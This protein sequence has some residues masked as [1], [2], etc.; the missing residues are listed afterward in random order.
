MDKVTQ[1]AIMRGT[2]IVLLVT[3][4]AILLVQISNALL[5]FFAAVIIA[6]LFNAAGGLFR[7]VGLPGHLATAL[8][9]LLVL[10]ILSLLIWLFAVE[11]AGQWAE[12][13]QRFSQ[14]VSM[15]QQM[16][17]NL[18]YSDAILSSTDGIPNLFRRVM[19]FAFG[20]IGVLT[21]L[22]LVLIGAVYLAAQPELYARGF[23]LL[24]P[25]QYGDKVEAALMATG[26]AL[27]SYLLGQFVTMT[28]IGLLVWIGLSLIGMPSAAALGLIIALANF[29]PMVG[30]FI[31]AAP[32][33]LIAFAQGPQMALYAFLVYLIAQQLEGNII[34]PLV[35]RRAVSIP[36]ALL[37]FTLAA[38]AVLFGI[39]GVILA[40]PL[41]VVVYTLVIMLWT[42][43]TLGHDVDL[44]A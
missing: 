41:A 16:L 42:R 39:I 6:V 21:N 13:N 43:D 19:N 12:L 23:R 44:P 37:I 35:Q 3:G 5:L 34:T 18:P 4:L 25:K 22:I 7:K 20:L 11:F 40:A 2:L 28:I 36:P 9:I 38:F 1:A 24:F 27:K 10:F 29:V 15:V 26:R 33:I 32:G 31:G 30:P 14:A 17:G 8:G